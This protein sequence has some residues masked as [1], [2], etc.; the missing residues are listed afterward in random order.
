MSGGLALL[1]V[2]A[3]LAVFGVFVFIQMV[4]LKH[5]VGKTWAN[6]GI[7]LKQ[8]HDELPKLVEPASNTCNS[9]RRHWKRSCVH[10]T[11]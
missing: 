6:I 9:S 4:T 5:N 3:L 1:I 8:R 10:A 2:L 11:L 7:L